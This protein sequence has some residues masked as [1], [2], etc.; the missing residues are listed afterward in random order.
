MRGCVA[1][2]A[3]TTL[4][5]SCIL[6]VGRL[7]PEQEPPFRTQFHA[8]VLSRLLSGYGSLKRSNSPEWLSLNVVNVQPT[9]F[10][11]R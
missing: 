7:T 10:I 5:N 4:T 2:V 11:E 1:P 6:A 3:R 9:V 8:A